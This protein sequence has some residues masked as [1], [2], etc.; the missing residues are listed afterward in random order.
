MSKGKHGIFG[1]HKLL[2]LTLTRSLIR[3]DLGM[4]WAMFGPFG[5]LIWALAL[6]STYEVGKKM[7]FTLVWTLS[8][9]RI[10]LLMDVYFLIDSP[11][12]LASQQP[13]IL[14]VRFGKA[15]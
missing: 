11:W 3:V 7:Y 6:G 1:Q 8:V 5:L 12:I 15:R 14:S 10:R 2:T 9:G 13:M 4:F